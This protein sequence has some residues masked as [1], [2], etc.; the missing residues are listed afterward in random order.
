VFSELENSQ[1]VWKERKTLKMDLSHC[2]LE[3]LLLDSTV[4]FKYQKIFLAEKKLA[5][6]K[7]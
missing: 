2:E 6:K 7:S 1:N 5:G 3:H 4:L